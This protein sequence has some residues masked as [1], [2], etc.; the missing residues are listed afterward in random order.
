MFACDKPK[1]KPFPSLIDK[2]TTTPLLCSTME[3]SFDPEARSAVVSL[4]I[5]GGNSNMVP[6][7]GG[8]PGR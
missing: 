1:M 3:A 7:M 2:A 5:Q 6:S 4:A 8:A